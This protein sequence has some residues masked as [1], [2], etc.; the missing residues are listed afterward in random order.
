MSV[1]GT[2]QMQ[3]NNLAQRFDRGE[4]ESALSSLQQLLRNNRSQALHVAQIKYLLALWHWEHNYFKKA[5]RYIKQALIRL[6]Q[7]QP[8][9]VLALLL[10]GHIQNSLANY[11][12]AIK[13][14]WSALQIAIQD[15]NRKA[16]A[17]AYL[18][19][20]EYYLINNEA[21]RAL[22]CQR[23]AYEIAKESN[24]ERTLFK[25]ILYLLQ[26]LNNQSLNDE[27]SPVL[28]D[29]W[30]LSK[31]IHI[32]QAWLSELQ[33][34]TGVHYLALGNIEL[35]EE[36]LRL[37][38]ATNQQ[39]NLLWGQTQNR[40]ALAKV[41]VQQGQLPQA[42]AMLESTILI[43]SSFDQG[44]LQQIICQQLSDVRQQEGNYAAA[45]AAHET[46]HQLAVDY[47]IKVK[48]SLKQL[49]NKQLIEL[50]RRQELINYQQNQI[51]LQRKNEIL[52]NQLNNACFDALTHCP[53]QRELK[54]NPPNAQWMYLFSIDNLA[55]VNASA[56]FVA[57]DELLK[58]FSQQ[59]REL[60]LQLNAKCYRWSGFQ[61][62]LLSNH[63][64][65]EN[66]I[67]ILNTHFSV[68]TAQLS[69]ISL[70]YDATATHFNAQPCW[71][72]PAG[73]DH[74]QS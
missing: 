42:A 1:S 60:S 27:I 36:Y 39:E 14:F 25:T 49:S 35:A 15:D 31:L 73:S 47:Q 33:H 5:L 37:S 59:L 71:H 26:N 34:H 41:L 20:G 45:L 2:F 56:G 23:N 32:E 10:L 19:I 57:G 11:S 63:A 67:D 43:A 38:L 3:Y 52:Q 6:P 53:N 68:C 48:R 4:G 70:A 17:Q 7:N 44:Y 74:A 58:D 64:A 54:L 18:G 13:A 24:D 55:S 72:S 29:G 9:Y 66:L 40:L 65:P 51:Q 46:Y 8:Q 61:F 69:L 12:A 28:N 30:R 21:H 22:N 62:M 16:I 50:D